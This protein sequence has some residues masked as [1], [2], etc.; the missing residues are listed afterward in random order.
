MRINDRVCFLGYKKD[1]DTVKVVR[2]LENLGV[3]WG[4]PET[5]ENKFDVIEHVLVGEVEQRKE[6]L[7]KLK[8]QDL[9][10]N[11]DEV[12]GTFVPMEG[13]WLELTCTIQWENEKPSEITPQKV[14]SLH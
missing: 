9:Q 12:E 7:V 10:F 13:D 4:D 8:G 14:Q 6:R 1:E 5:E 3:A 11:L 2:I